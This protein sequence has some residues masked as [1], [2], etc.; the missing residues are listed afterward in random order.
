MSGLLE[1]WK[2]RMPRANDYTHGDFANFYNLGNTLWY[3]ILIGMNLLDS[4][5]AKNELISWN[6]YNT[7][8]HHYNERLL[9][10][11]FVINKAYSTN[12]FYKNQIDYLDDFQKVK[13]Y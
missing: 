2:T 6:L 1:L 13:I 3:Q 8:E 10:N 9:F 5:L 11:K 7:A 12:D 4:E